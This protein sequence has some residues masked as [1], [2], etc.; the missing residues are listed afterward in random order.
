MCKSVLLRNIFN[1]NEFSNLQTEQDSQKPISFSNV[2]L[3]A[4]SY[5]QSNRLYENMR[6]CNTCQQ[7]AHSVLQCSAQTTECTTTITTHTHKHS[8]FS[9]ILKP[10]KG[11][12]MK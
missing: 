5:E 2:S 1:L 3:Y 6:L 11:S 4:W 8:E 10:S 12:I 9:D 7:S